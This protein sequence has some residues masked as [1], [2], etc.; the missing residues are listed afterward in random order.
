MNNTETNIC[1]EMASWVI[2]SGIYFLFPG[3][4]QLCLHWQNPLCMT[5]CFGASNNL[6][7]FPPY[8][9]HFKV[10]VAH[11][12]TKQ[13]HNCGICFQKP[14][15]PLKSKNHSSNAPGLLLCFALKE[16]KS[17]SLMRKSIAKP[18]LFQVDDAAAPIHSFLQVSYTRLGIPNGIP[19][20]L[21][22]RPFYG[23]SCNGLLLSLWT[24]SSLN[25]PGG[26][27]Q[28]D[29]GSTFP[30][31]LQQRSQPTE[32]VDGTL[33]RSGSFLIFFL[34]WLYSTRLESLRFQSPSQ[35]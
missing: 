20:D 5:T 34:F 32:G 7:I 12:Q 28:R 6:N 21:I 14:K 27:G 25:C 4:G 11:F 3:D 31:S 1:S 30:R 16:K 2:H 23:S 19:Y 17:L 22:M 33:I 35:E 26:S 10:K 29:S 15:T 18:W 24:V 13:F 9:L 8:I